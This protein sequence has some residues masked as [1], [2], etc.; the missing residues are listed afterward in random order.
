MPAVVKLFFM[1]GAIWY[2]GRADDH[3]GLDVSQ[4]HR[5]TDL[6]QSCYHGIEHPLLARD[7]SA[8]VGV[9]DLVLIDRSGGVALLIEQPVIEAACS[10]FMRICS[11]SDS[12]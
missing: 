3:L 11:R 10:S 12:R 5:N 1:S 9:L 7:L 6:F 4:I 8:I 2:R